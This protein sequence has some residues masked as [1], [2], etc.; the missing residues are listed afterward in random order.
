LA[1]DRLVSLKEASKQLRLSKRMLFYRI[2]R[3]DLKAI[4]HEGGWQLFIA[5]SEIEAV[6]DLEWYRNSRRLPA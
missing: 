5:Q 2:R 6:K 1:E 3:G 4:R